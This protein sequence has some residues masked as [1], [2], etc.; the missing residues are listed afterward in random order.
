MMNWHVKKEVDQKMTDWC[1][2][3][4]MANTIKELS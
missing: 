1:E 2:K 4:L 3:K